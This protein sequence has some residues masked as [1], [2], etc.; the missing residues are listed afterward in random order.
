MDSG[1]I[2]YIGIIG[3]IIGLALI[4]GFFVLVH[5]VKDIHDLLQ[6]WDSDRNEQKDREEKTNP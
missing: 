4:I 1:M 3:S 2:M 6:R 5:Y